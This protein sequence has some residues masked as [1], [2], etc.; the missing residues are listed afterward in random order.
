M[1]RRITVPA[2]HGELLPVHYNG[3]HGDLVHEP[4]EGALVG[5]AVVAQLPPHQKDGT[6]GAPQVAPG[7]V[8]ALVPQ[9]SRK[10]VDDDCHE[11]QRYCRVEGLSG[12][13]ELKKIIFK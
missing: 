5:V 6:R 4:Q 1:G 12:V 8:Q 10:N 13:V 2:E 9:M 7:Q 3:S 11:D